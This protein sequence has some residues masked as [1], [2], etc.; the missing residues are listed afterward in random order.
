MNDHS[1]NDGL[2]NLV[3]DDVNS[4]TID[5]SVDDG[6]A[7]SGEAGTRRRIDAGTLLFAGIVVA[8]IVGLWSMRTLGR[9][10][11]ASMAGGETVKDVREWVWSRSG[12]DARESLGGL[13]LIDRLDKARLNELQVPAERL[14]NP[15]PFEYFMENRRTVEVVNQ[16]G[17]DQ[18]ATRRLLRVRWEKLI[19]EIGRQMSVTAIVAPDTSRAQA[20]LNGHRIMAGDIFHVDHMGEEYAFK[21]ERIGPHGVVFFAEN[22]S[23]GH[24][25]R[26]EIGVKRGW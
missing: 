18:A 8:S 20:V 21:V 14:A 5:F 17:D 1:I 9:S 10:S 26:L 3:E 19:N 13:E 2:D 7:N 12:R 24:D 6:F 25:H 23:L 16:T 11:A 15:S 4:G 22:A